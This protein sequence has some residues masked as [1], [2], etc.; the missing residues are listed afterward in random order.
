MGCYGP[1]P[2]NCILLQGQSKFF[3]PSLDLTLNITFFIYCYFLDQVSHPTLRLILILGLILD[4]ILSL[5][6]LSIP[7][8]F[9]HSFSISLHL[10]SQSGPASQSSC[11]CFPH[12]Q[13]REQ[14]GRHGVNAGWPCPP[15]LS[16]VWH[17]GLGPS[18]EGYLDGLPPITRRCQGAVNLCGPTRVR[19]HQKKAGV[20]SIA[21]LV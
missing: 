4:H 12:G 15:A 1:S 17:M 9:L 13:Y 7:V 11:S 8:F 2:H 5:H 10:H 21:C 18:I 6:L 20:R 19:D 16:P 3:V 14:V